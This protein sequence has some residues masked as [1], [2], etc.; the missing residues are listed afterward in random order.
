MP[1]IPLSRAAFA[2]AI[3]QKPAGRFM[4][5]IRNARGEVAPGGRLVST[6]TRVWKSPLKTAAILSGSFAPNKKLADYLIRQHFWFYG[7]GSFEPPASSLSPDG[8]AEFLDTRC[9]AVS[10]YHDPWIKSGNTKHHES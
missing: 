4:I 7:R 2:A 9:A 8:V 6:N 10:Y 3:A 5:R 1:P